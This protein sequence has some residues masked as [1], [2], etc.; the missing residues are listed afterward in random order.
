MSALADAS[1]S[2]I[3]LSDDAS[4][5]FRVWKVVQNMLSK[6][7]YG[8]LESDQDMK[9]DAFVQRFGADPD[10][11]ALTILAT[12]N[13][14]KEQLIVY[15]CSD[16]KVGVKRIEGYSTQMKENGIKNAILILRLGITP[17]AKEG[18]NVSC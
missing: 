15:F 2:G 3:A 1:G 12:H 7:G 6:R 11:D 8:V 17:F 4:R 5:L 13:D 9:R 14:N 16:E 10:R 18:L